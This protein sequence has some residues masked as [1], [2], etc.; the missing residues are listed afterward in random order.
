M[1]AFT[2]GH[3]KLGGRQAGTPNKATTEFREAIRNAFDAIGG[4]S[5]FSAWAAENP[6]EFYKI[7]GRLIPV[8]L[9]GELLAAT[10]EKTIVIVNRS[11]L[12]EQPA[13][14]PLALEQQSDDL[15]DD[16]GAP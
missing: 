7:C 16:E 15:S 9:R 8:E 4:L 2:H 13:T 12:R 6:T 1:A 5:A 14:V 10:Q 11:V 3:E